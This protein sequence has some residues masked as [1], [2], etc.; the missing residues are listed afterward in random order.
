M[1]QLSEK[2]SRVSYD[3]NIFRQVCAEEGY[4]PYSIETMVELITD[5]TAD[6]QTILLDVVPCERWKFSKNY[7]Q[8]FL[9]AAAA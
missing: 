6:M 9:A 1:N 2:Q 8:K 5:P 4:E 3:E 7:R